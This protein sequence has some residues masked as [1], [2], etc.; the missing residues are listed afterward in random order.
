MRDELHLSAPVLSIRVFLLLNLREGSMSLDKDDLECPNC[1]YVSLT[2]EKMADEIERLRA[3]ETEQTPAGMINWKM[4]A[5]RANR[6]LADASYQLVKE[7]R[8][9]FYAGYFEGRPPIAVNG[10]DRA[11]REE[12]AAW[13]QYAE[14]NG[15]PLPD[16]QSEPT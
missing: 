10:V 15:L 4:E 2:S 11:V 13:K 5:E 1:G 3:E 7:T 14:E 16:E 12:E 6:L 8:D 9:A